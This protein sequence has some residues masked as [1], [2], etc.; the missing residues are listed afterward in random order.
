MTERLNTFHE[1]AELVKVV[2]LATGRWSLSPLRPF[3]SLPC[4]L[5]VGS[6]CEPGACWRPLQVGAAISLTV[7]PKGPG[8]RRSHPDRA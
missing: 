8:V 3:A 4:A 5:C 1:K 7:S 6:R 2:D